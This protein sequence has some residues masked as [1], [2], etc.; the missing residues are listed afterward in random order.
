MPAI[1]VV[2][3]SYSCPEEELAG[4]A[5]DFVEN[6]GPE[7]EGLIWKI[8]LHQPEQRQAGGNLSLQ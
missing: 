2:R 4:P 1:T 3:F 7:T 5:N 8:F 6:V